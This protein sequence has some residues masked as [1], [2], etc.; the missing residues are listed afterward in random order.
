MQ[1][2]SP[3]LAGSSDSTKNGVSFIGNKKIFWKVVDEPALAR[4][5]EGYES[6]AQYYPVPKLYGHLYLGD[7]QYALCFEYEESIGEEKG[8]LVDLFSTQERLGGGF[9][10][11]I[12]M[13]RDAFLKTLSKRNTT[14]SD[15]FF[16]ERVRERIPAYYSTGF[17][18]TDH[19]FVFNNRSVYIQPDII[20]NDIKQYFSSRSDSW[21]VISQCD[22]N[23]LNIGTLPV[24]FD[25][26]A[27]GYV[28][29]MAEFATLFWYQLAQGSYLAPIYNKEAFKD[30]QRIYARMDEVSLVQ[31]RL[32]HV[33]NNLRIQFLREYVTQVIQPCLANMPDDFNWYEE[34]KNHFAMKILGVF[35]ISKMEKKDM[36]LSLGYLHLF[37][38]ANIPNIEDLFKLID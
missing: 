8:L 28:P 1:T 12:Q 30:H 36:L 37:Y 34:F 17:L 32:T 22:P 9:A 14:S 16:S 25:Y 7:G 21:S 38:T 11:I 23:D 27:G 6:V 20:V 18:S 33:P 15:V 5:I 19:E 26:T 29:L 2:N 4:E 13:Y 3:R 31:N 10:V 35:N 24:L